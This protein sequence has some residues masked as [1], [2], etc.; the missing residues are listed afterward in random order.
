MALCL[1]PRHCACIDSIAHV[2]NTKTKFQEILHCRPQELDILLTKKSIPSVLDSP[3]LDTYKY[4][5]LANQETL[6]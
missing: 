4:K 2:K 5:S 3:T 1:Q 6:S